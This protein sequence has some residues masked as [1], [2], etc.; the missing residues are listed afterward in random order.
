MQIKL[1]EQEKEILAYIENRADASAKDIAKA[2]GY[3]TASIQYILRK[4]R[5][6]N[7][8]QSRVLINLAK[9]GYSKYSFSFSLASQADKKREN[10]ENTLIEN[11]L[12][13]AIMKVSGS[14]EYEVKIVVA[15][16]SQLIKFL[17][18]LSIE[19][20]DFFSKKSLSLQIFSASLGGRKLH[21]K[22]LEPNLLS[23]SEVIKKDKIDEKD[24][25][26]LKALCNQQILSQSKIRKITGLP[27]TTIER[28]IKSLEKREI[29][30]G[31]TNRSKQSVIKEPLF[32]LLI[33]TRTFGVDF[34]KNLY[35]YSKKCPLITYY[36]S[37]IGE[38]DFMLAV[39]VEEESEI[40][41]IKKDLLENFTESIERIRIVNVLQ[42][43]KVKDYPFIDFPF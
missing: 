32:L 23:L 19:Y 28:R 17:N 11:E 6:S 3:K 21:E 22:N 43:L 27:G 30:V 25:Q 12:V 8:I 33:N 7:L 36:V 10:I 1:S 37:Y 42:V 4:F 2:T 41:Q 5:S 34:H 14:F 20:G 38:Y 15:N 13:S 16:S 18:K 29:I 40:N 31:Y 24:H 26:I 9:I 35:S 39:Q